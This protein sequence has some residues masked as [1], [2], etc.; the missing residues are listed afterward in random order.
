MSILFDNDLNHRAVI[1][2]I[3]TKEGVGRFIIIKGVLREMHR[4][5]GVLKMDNR[6]IAYKGLL[7]RHLIMPDGLAGTKDAVEFIARKLSPDSYVNIMDQYRP[8]YKAFNYPEIAR[9]ITAEEYDE[10]IEL[11][12][13]A[14]LY[15][16]F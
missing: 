3:G 10:A 12:R 4:Q 6:G 1:E 2:L 14:G 16:G 5:V 8:C 11:A 9:R 13:E 15:R 7:I